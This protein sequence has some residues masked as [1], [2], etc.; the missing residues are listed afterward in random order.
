MPTLV[1]GL[2]R[3]FCSFGFDPCFKNCV[4][5]KRDV[6]RVGLRH[7]VNDDARFGQ[8]IQDNV[9][10]RLCFRGLAEAGIMQN[11]QDAEADQ[12]SFH[13]SFRSTAITQNRKLCSDHLDKKVINAQLFSTCPPKRAAADGQCTRRRSQTSEGPWMTP[14]GRTAAFTAAAFVRASA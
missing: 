13:G 9:K 5:C 3:F 10:G 12:T 2:Y 1:T 6:W 4:A 14:P 8:R 11:H 7:P